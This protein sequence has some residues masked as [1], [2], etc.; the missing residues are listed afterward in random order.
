MDFNLT[1]LKKDNIEDLPERPATSVSNDRHVA[2]KDAIAPYAK[3]ADQKKSH[4]CIC[5]LQNT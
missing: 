1:K 4:Q 3:K 5:R 2:M